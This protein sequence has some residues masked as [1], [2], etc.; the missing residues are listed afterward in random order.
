MPA[1]MPDRDAQIVAAYE[2]GESKADLAARFGIG[3]VRI[4][5]IIL[6]DRRGTKR[7]P[8]RIPESAKPCAR[9]GCKERARGDDW[10]SRAHFEAD[11]AESNPKAVAA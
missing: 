9:R 5:Q 3:K 8:G 6:A 10:C 4:G 1:P 2:A 7:K 11:F